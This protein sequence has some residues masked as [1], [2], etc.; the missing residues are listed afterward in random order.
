M[1][2]MRPWVVIHPGA[3]APSRRYPPERFAKVGQRLVSELGFQ[4]VFTGMGDEHAL[5]EYIQAAMGAPSFSTAGR[6]DL[7]M[8]VALISLAPVLVAN[9]SGPAH[10][11]AAVGTPVVDLYALTNPQHTPWAVESRVLFQD[12]PCKYCYKSICPEGHQRCL[13]LVSP[14]DVIRATQELLDARLQRA[15]ARGRGER[16]FR[17][18]VEDLAG[19]YFRD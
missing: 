6:L 4:A 11:A 3:T 13:S 9:N 18:P 2:P 5:I 1:D 17:V 19:V 16:D 10:I 15:G 8:L 14:E 12:V 7:P